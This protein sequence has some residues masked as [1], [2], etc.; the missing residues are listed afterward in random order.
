MTRR[1]TFNE[2]Y[3]QCKERK[4]DLPLKVKNIKIGKQNCGLNVLDVVKSICKKL[5]LI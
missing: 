1:K 2:Y 3:T 5:I 4:Y